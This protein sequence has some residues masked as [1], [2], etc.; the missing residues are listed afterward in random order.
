M[1]GG[2]NGIIM[3]TTTLHR[4]CTCGK[5]TTST[6]PVKDWVLTSI[7]DHGPREYYRYRVKG[8]NLNYPP[9]HRDHLFCWHV[10][11]LG[12]RYDTSELTDGK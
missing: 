6:P 12:E 1:P 10:P 7:H 4:D 8:R 5:H 2:Y 11:T 3:T 9:C